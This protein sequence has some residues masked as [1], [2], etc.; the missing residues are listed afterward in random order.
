[1][2]SKEDSLHLT[3]TDFTVFRKSHFDFVNGVNV[4]VGGNGTGKTHALKALY[5]SVLHKVDKQQPAELIMGVFNVENPDEV[6]SFKGRRAILQGHWSGM[7]RTFRIDVEENEISYMDDLS[8]WQDFPR[9]VFIPAQ[10]MMSHTR[11]FLS[12]YQL[13]KIDFDQTQRDIVTLLLSP[14]ARDEELTRGLRHSIESA[15]GGTILERNERFYLRSEDRETPMPMVAEGFRK[16]ATLDQLVA[17]GFLKKGTMLFWDEP[18]ANLNPSMYPLVVSALFEIAS[19]GVQVF[20][21]THEYLI[22]KELELQRS[23]RSLRYHALEKT[24]EGVVVNRA[25][26]YL[27][28]QPNLIEEEFLSVYDRSV[29]LDIMERAE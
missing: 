3:L 14:E 27:D 5:L 7:N 12:T 15:I 18:E 29:E 26:E 23:G 6:I 20:V 19:W 10:D 2:K 16:L 13:Y 28:I 8:D 1:M 21:A 22:L 9:P 25:D 17:N 24:P 11:R 4:L